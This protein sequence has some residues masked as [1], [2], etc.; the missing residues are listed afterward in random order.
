VRGAHSHQGAEPLEVSDYHANQSK[1][2]LTVEALVVWWSDDGRRQREARGNRKLIKRRRTMKFIQRYCKM[3]FIGQLY[4]VF[5][6]S[7]NWH[8][9]NV[10]SEY[11]PDKNRACSGFLRVW[12]VGSKLPPIFQHQ[13]WLSPSTVL[14]SG[15]FHPRLNAAAARTRAAGINQHSCRNC[16]NGGD[17]AIIHTIWSANG[18]RR[19]YWMQPNFPEYSQ[20]EI[21]ASCLPFDWVSLRCFVASGHFFLTLMSNAESSLNSLLFSSFADLFL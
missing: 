6:R 4:R 5:I 15:R 3:S 18:E 12:Q 13:C 1:P 10:N 7:M 2:L 9:L 17:E 21:S 20:P 16:Q 11:C 19:L 8:V 14:K